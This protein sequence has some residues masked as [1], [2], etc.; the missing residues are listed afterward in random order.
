MTPRQLRQVP[1]TKPVR[2][3][4]DARVG[5]VWYEARARPQPWAYHVSAHGY[6]HV[7]A[8]RGNPPAGRRADLSAFEARE[9]HARA[10]A[11]ALTTA[12]KN[13]GNPRGPRPGLTADFWGSRF[14]VTW[15]TPKREKWLAFWAMTCTLSRRLR[16]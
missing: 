7:R 11:D 12:S 6:L 5:R 16:C 2:V 10:A 9:P 4:A 1:Q 13:P 15:S 14:T 3:H 8:L